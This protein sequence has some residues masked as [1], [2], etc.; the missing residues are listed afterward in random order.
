MKN[1]R[2]FKRAQHWKILYLTGGASKK[3]VSRRFKEPPAL[4]PDFPMIFSKPLIYA[5]MA[6]T[7]Q[8]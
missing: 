1:R 3:R 5:L 8:G 7:T 4:A 2:F 6:R